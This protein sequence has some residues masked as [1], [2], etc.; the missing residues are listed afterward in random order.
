MVVRAHAGCFKAL[1]S[2]GNLRRR[3]PVAAKT[4][5]AIAGTMADVPVSPIPPGGSALGMIWTSIAG[6]SFLRVIW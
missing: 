2:T 3:L 5:L 6:A 4:A 1:A